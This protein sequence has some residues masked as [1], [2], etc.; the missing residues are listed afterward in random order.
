MVELFKVKVRKI[1]TSL[2]VLLPQ[3]RLRETRVAEGEELEIAII[4]HVKNLTG[5]GMAR[6]FKIPFLRDKEDRNSA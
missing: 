6:K 3:D 5:F 1:G 4:P 2:G